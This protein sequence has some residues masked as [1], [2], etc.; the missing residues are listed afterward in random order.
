MHRYFIKSTEQITPSTLL[1]TLEKDADEARL[2]S[3][4][5]GQYAAISFKRNHRPS[6]ARCF[7]IV[8]SPTDQSILQFSMRTRG[9]YTS[10]LTKLQVGDE[11][12]VRGPFGGFVFDVERDKKAVF[13]AGGIGIT[14][15]M[16]MMQYATTIGLKNE[17]TLLY[18]VATQDD[19]PFF[20][21]L[22]KMQARNPKLKVVYVVGNGPSNKLYGYTHESGFV[23][24]EVIEKHA[25]DYAEATYFACG[26]PPF[27]NGVLKTLQKK[28]VS[29][30]KLITEAFSQGPNRQSGKVVSWPQNMYIM[31]GVGMAL[32]TLSIMVSDITKSLPQTPFV[33]GENAL[34]LLSDPNQ[35]EEDL[36]SM[37]NDLPGLSEKKSSSVA[38]VNALKK[39]KAASSANKTSSA[40]ASAPTY[41]SAAPSSSAS[42]GSSKS[43]SA[44]SSTGGGTTASTPAPTPTPTPVCTTSQSG[45]TTCN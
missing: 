8:S 45:V 30:N 4:Q 24:E 3:F 41:Y 20:D 42:S 22:K 44:G 26:P 29:K 34:E 32:G 10:A 2:F 6:V 28:G 5:P 43:T 19:I 7:S 1:L 9:R 16:S 38:V 33:S 18:G 11:V 35:R 25:S 14:P 15:F 12:N 36:D 13:A 40:S 17:I 31:G 27:M 39:S 23:N 37:V 21:Q